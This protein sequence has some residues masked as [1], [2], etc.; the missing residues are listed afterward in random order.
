MIHRFFKHFS[1][2]SLA[3][4]SSLLLPA[5]LVVKERGEIVVGFVCLVCGAHDGYGLG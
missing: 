4:F 1:N 2:C 5:S 3:A